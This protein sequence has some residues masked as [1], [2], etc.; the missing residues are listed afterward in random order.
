MIDEIAWI[1]LALQGDEKAF[2]ALVETYQKPVYNLCYRM[3]GQPEAAEDAAQET[4]LRVYQN[5]VRYDRARSFPTWLLS[6][7]A[8][9]CIDILRRRRI[10]PLMIDGEEGQ[11]DLPDPCAPEPELEVAGR[12]DR[13][14]LQNCLKFLDPTNRAAVILRYWQ[15]YSEREIAEALNLTVPAVRLRLHRSRRFLADLWD[16]KPTHLR[17]ERK[18]SESPAY[19]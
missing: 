15:D 18:P 5:L 3:L 9:H 19:L 6:I 1:N 2:T 10:F 11:I 13:D 14:R 8:H 4:F 16:E 7:A 17:S 12:Q